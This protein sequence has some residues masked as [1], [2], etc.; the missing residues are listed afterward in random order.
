[1]SSTVVLPA[2]TSIL[3]FVFALA[4][5]DQWRERRREF[6]LVWA[7]GMLSYGVAAGCE[8]IGEGFGWTDGLFRGWFSFGVATPALLGLG[9]AF[10]LNRTRFGYTYAFVV[11]LSAILA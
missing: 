7:I 1:M 3:A 2:I 9:S 8:A 11:V 4:L 5:I 6:Q 10:L